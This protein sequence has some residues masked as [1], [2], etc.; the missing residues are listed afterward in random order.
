MKIFKLSFSF[1]FVLHSALYAQVDRS[2]FPEPGPAPEIE[3]NDAESF[4]LDNGLKVFVVSNDKLPRVA[5]YLV[6]DRDPLYEGDKA[7]LTGFVGE[8][9]MAGTS[10]RTK[11]ELDEEID[12]IG[13]SIS[14]GS[15][16]LSGSSLKKHQE[17]VLELMTDVLYNPVF[18]ESEL[19]KLKKQALTSL[20]S[21]K[22]DP[23][24][25]AGVVSSALVYG[26]D[27]PYG[28][29]Q[30]E[31]S[32]ENVTLEDIREYYHTYY[33]P[34]IAYLAIV[35][36]I[37]KDEAEKLVEQYFSKWEK[38]EVP[39]KSYEMPTP[40]SES[41]VALLD[42]SNAVQSV[43]NLGY[44]LDMHVTN[45]DFLAT[46]V[47]NFI[48][49][50]GFNSRLNAN[51]REDKGYTYGARSSIGSDRLV[52]RFSANTSV[53]TEVTDS[54]VYEMIYEIRNL[55]ENGITEQELKTAKANLSGRFGRSLE[56]PSTIASFAINIARYGLPEDFYSSYLQRLDALTEEEI[57][58]AAK[59][60]LKPENLH[61]TVVGNGSE[62]REK[63]QQFGEIRLYN[64]RG[65]EVQEIQLSEADLTAEEVI[66]KYLEAIGG[67]DAAEN[68]T[69]ARISMSAEIQGM[70]LDMISLHD[71]PN[72]RMIQ[73]VV[74]MGNE[75]SKTVLK[76]GEAVVS[77]MGQSQ[78][79]TDEQYEDVKMSSLWIVP[80]LHYESLGYTLSLEGIQDVDGEAAYKITVGNP[81]GGKL[82]NYY[83]VDSGL[84]LRSENEL[85]GET[86][87]IAYETFEGVKLPV[88]ISLKNPMIP[89]PLNSKIESLE[90]N[91][92]FTDEDFN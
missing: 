53:R 47:L 1:L 58:H 51:L 67:R 76:N 33:K 24:Y 70:K 87:Y 66:S 44:P 21:S 45:E 52:A 81:T 15:T 35:G 82:S 6:L 84:K 91:V 62:I 78:T 16:S 65:D 85:S 36:D 73:K 30:T 13:A 49:G 63:L 34:N 83:S 7:G 42:R 37:Q 92:P 8:M 40:P 17:K 72:Q 74:M 5:F 18:P 50:E 14:A 39:K 89:V 46:R 69:T 2:V 3:F 19:E 64:N 29:T 86:D 27:H 57:N 56:N 79:L 20:A 41:R 71:A 9:M 43:L 68:I 80:E 55:A 10:G 48:L 12:F 26:K 23:D 88:E 59:K 32:I 60:Y 11:D 28:E 31:K 22:D 77:A 4:E 90:V 75:A 38:G 61:I 54:A 25:L